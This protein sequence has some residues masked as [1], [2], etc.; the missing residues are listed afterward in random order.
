MLTVVD[1]TRHRD[2]GLD[3]RLASGDLTL[4]GLE[5]LAHED[6]VDV[7]RRDACPLEGGRDG[8]TSE[9][10]RRQGGEGA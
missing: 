3:R 9:V 6:V 1:G 10:H 7:L 5:H 8:H 4:A 2:A